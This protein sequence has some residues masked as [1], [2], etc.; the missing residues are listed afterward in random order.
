MRPIIRS[1]LY[2]PADSGDRL[3]RA[4]Q[5]GADAVIADLEDSVAPARKTAARAAAAAWIAQGTGTGGF[6]RWLRVN[7]SH[8]G[9]ADLHCVFRPGLSGVC[10][11]K[12]SGAAEVQAAANAL[13]DLESRHGCPV[14]STAL[15]PLIE[16]GLGLRR[17]DEIAEGPRVRILQLGEIDLAADLGLPPHPHRDD[18][19]PL[20]SAL[21]VASAAAGLQPPVGAVSPQF[22]DMDAFRAT[23]AR[24]KL[25]GFLGRAAIHPAQVPVI[26]EIFSISPDELA[27]ARATVSLYDVALAAGEGAAAAG[28]G[29]MVDEATVRTSR[30]IIALAAAG[31]LTERENEPWA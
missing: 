9:I 27:V 25:A 28:E 8:Q 29:R 30:R 22:H 24:L 15:M 17:V 7:P 11:A 6:E 2:V 31:G 5:R 4:G 12:T 16:S 20:R 23:T 21:V 18:L 3:T 26:H 10:L 1:F 13:A 19:A 14:G